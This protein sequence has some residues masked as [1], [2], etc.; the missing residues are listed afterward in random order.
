MSSDRLIEVK[1]AQETKSL[2]I[3]PLII[4]LIFLNL[5]YDQIERLLQFFAFPPDFFFS[6]IIFSKARDATWDKK[7]LET[8]CPKTVHSF[9]LIKTFSSR[10]LR[11]RRSTVPSITRSLYWMGYNSWNSGCYLY[12][13]A[14]IPS[15][16]NRPVLVDVNFYI[17]NLKKLN[18]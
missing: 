12:L 16:A 2:T 8:V 6:L 15:T 4:E 17:Y 7:N 10:R 1:K 13:L 18:S 3:E 14:L 5:I 11:K 9:C